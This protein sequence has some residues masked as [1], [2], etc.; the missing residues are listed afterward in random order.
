MLFQNQPVVAI[1]NQHAYALF[2]PEHGGRLLSWHVNGQQIIHWPDTA[3]WSNPRKIRG[4][5]PLLFP[6]IARHMVDGEP[7][8]WIDETGSRR[9][10]P[11]HGFA[12]SLPFTY[13]VS[14]DHAEITM[15]LQDNQQTLR[16]FPYPFRLEVGY[17]L[18]GNALEVTLSTW[19]PGQRPLPYYP[20]HHFYFS[21]PKAMRSASTIHL[22]PTVRQWFRPDGEISAPEPG[23]MHYQLS[24]PLIQDCFHV[25]QSQ[26]DVR[27]STPALGREITMTLAVPGSIPWHAVTTWS[28]KPDDDYYCVEPWTGLPNAIHHHQGLRW[29]Q[30]GQQ[31]KAICIIK[32]AFA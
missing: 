20:G 17:R 10:M 21:L 5:N 22:P 31:E 23:Q 18:L 26:Q 27:I 32:A 13:A 6:F 11:V 9:E 15:T 14:G 24:D 30:P 4:G 8:W 19:N 2:A 29:L 16:Y 1:R 3:D 28:E 7:G 25:L 12:H